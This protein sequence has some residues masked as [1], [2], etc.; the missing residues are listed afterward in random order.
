MNLKI[1]IISQISKINI[2]TNTI[3]RKG[4]K[5]SMA[6]KKCY[7]VGFHKSVKTKDKEI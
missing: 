4:G 2:E 1:I 3:P 7:K 5:N 6:R